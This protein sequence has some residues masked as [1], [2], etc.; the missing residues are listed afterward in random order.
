M[1]HLHSK[2]LHQS[3]AIF[4]FSMDTGWTS[5]VNLLAQKNFN[6]FGCKAADSYLTKAMPFLLELIARQA[7]N[8]DFDINDQ[9]K[10]QEAVQKYLQEKFY[11]I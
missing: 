9:E 1:T 10:L 2:I 3:K 8:V 5:K 7:L 4:D 6:F 11:S